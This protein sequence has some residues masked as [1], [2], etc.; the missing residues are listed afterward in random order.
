MQ[1]MKTTGNTIAAIGQT[2]QDTA[3]LASL[4]V[5][6]EGENGRFL[7]TLFFYRYA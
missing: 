4:F 1:I 2:V 7:S 6:D 5:G 3:E